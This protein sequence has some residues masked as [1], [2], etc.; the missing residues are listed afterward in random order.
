MAAKE[1]CHSW[2]FLHSC[3]K[4]AGAKNILFLRFFFAEPNFAFG[5]TPKINF[6]FAFYFFCGQQHLVPGIKYFRK[7]LGFVRYNACKPWV[8]GVL[9]SQNQFALALALPHGTCWG[10]GALE[11]T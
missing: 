4:G 7:S 2:K 1:K 11:F 10:P 3:K 9:C 8:G 6:F 5:M